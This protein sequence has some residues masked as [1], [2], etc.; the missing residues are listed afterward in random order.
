TE[1]ARIPLPTRP[2]TNTSMACLLG[3]KPAGARNVA[4]MQSSLLLSMAHA[5]LEFQ[6]P[7]VHFPLF[8]CS[9][10]QD[11]R[12]AVNADSNS[13]ITQESTKLGGTVR[14]ALDLR[15]RPPFPFDQPLQRLVSRF[16]RHILPQKSR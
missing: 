2:M 10:F 7:T 11:R 16:G 15:L 6:R 5:L 8:Q 14:T 1:E 9:C 4:I 3:E 13:V 12:L